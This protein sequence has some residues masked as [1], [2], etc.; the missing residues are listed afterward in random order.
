MTKL[1][2][3][4]AK[5]LEITVSILGPKGSV[6]TDYLDVTKTVEAYIN[7]AEFPKIRARALKIAVS[8]I[9]QSPNAMNTR[10]NPSGKEARTHANDQILDKYSAPAAHIEQYIREAL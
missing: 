7:N 9:G 2:E 1:Q 8:M 4:R 3:I 5:A 6:E 10:Y